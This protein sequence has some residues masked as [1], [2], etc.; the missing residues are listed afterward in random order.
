ME[1][2]AGKSSHPLGVRML[3]TYLLFMTNPGPDFIYSSPAPPL[4]HGGFLPWQGP[5]FPARVLPYLYIPVLPM[6]LPIHLPCNPASSPHA[7]ALVV[8][9]GHCP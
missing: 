3:P 5:P 8:H 9:L 6:H 4:Q 2:E 1:R 7:L